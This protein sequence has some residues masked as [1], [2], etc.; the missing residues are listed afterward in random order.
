MWMKYCQLEFSGFWGG[1]V[2][3]I[4]RVPLRYSLHFSV[5]YVN[6]PG[7][8]LINQM[9]QGILNSHSDNLS[10]PVAYV[11]LYCNGVILM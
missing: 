7:F 6:N 1:C 9:I 10:N 4:S 2:S 5:M 8:V 3:V 11:R